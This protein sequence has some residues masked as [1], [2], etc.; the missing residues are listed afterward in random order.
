MYRAPA[1]P[2]LLVTAFANRVIGVV[3]STGQIAWEV[4]LEGLVTSPE[5]AI[6]QGVVIAV[7]M[8]FVT[9]IDHATGQLRGRVA[10]PQENRARPTII[11]H[12]GYLYI[13]RTGDLTCVSFSGQV[14]WSQ[15]FTGRGY[16]A[17]ALGFPG[18]IRQADHQG[19]R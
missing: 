16:G 14:M 6:E 17:M 10:L 13:G 9:F 12:D 19:S 8:D 7:N 4:V 1:D 11:V 18:N 3:P 15:P 5:I 2:P